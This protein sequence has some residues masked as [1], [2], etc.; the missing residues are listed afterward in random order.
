M[1]K[2]Y[3]LALLAAI[4]SLSN[5]RP[6]KEKRQLTK[7][8]I[9]I[10]L[11]NSYV[12]HLFDLQDHQQKDSL[13]FYLQNE[14]PTLRYLSALSF[15]SFKEKTAVDKLLPLLQADPS[16]EVRTAAAYA[17][18][19]IGE[20]RAEDGLLQAF[21]R[22]DTAFNRHLNATILEAIGKCG[23][24]KSLKA[25]ATVGTYVPSDTIL[26]EGQCRGIY[27]FALRDL[28]TSEG[29]AKMVNYA[30][31]AL[32]PASVRLLAASYLQRAKKIQPD[33]T[34]AVTLSKTLNT[35]SDP[36]LRMAVAIGLGKAKTEAALNALLRQ[37]ETDR[38]YRVQCNAIRGLGNFEYS[39]VA[40]KIYLFLKN[41]NPHV[42][43]TAAQF[44]LNNGKPTD[45]PDYWKWAKDDSITATPSLL[46]YGAALKHLSSGYTGSKDA[47]NSEL[48]KRFAQTT[49][50]YERV[51]IIRAMT[52]YPWNY[53]NIK[54]LTLNS[55]LPLLR[56][57]GIDALVEICKLP[58]FNSYFGDGRRRVREDMLGF[59][60]EALANG[61]VALVAGAAQALREPNPDFKIMVGEEKSFL[62]DALIKLKLPKE[63]ETYNELQKTIDYFN[64][65][66]DSSPKQPDFTHPIDWKIVSLVTEKTRAVIQTKYGNISLVFF[67]KIAPGS[68]ANFIQLSNS[69]FF[70]GK[71]FHRVVS[72]FVVQGGCPRGDGFGALDYAIRSEFNPSVRYE[73]EG[74]V[75]M[76]SSGNH[77]EGTQ[78]F[79]TNA[80]A[81]HLD[82][83]YT[84]FAKVVEGMDAVQKIQ[85]GDIIEKITVVY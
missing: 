68:V 44:F 39:K 78:W 77:T 2:I 10:D 8:G 38:D 26:L 48:S 71:T 76:A 32:M 46:L 80:P 22:Q 12:Q 40:P 20:A 21:Q 14:N 47:I 60:K 64:G 70:N 54:A 7:T 31:D 37:L 81:P 52:Q 61:D 28:T 11:S 58:N 45:A 53:R 15:A 75:G 55:D 3:F 67:P 79:I 69:G 25:L 57:A 4:A 35:E 73:T 36:S 72:N 16:L 56:T 62:N 74:M 63:I 49:N 30:S 85:V 66:T 24:E 19:Q 43:N 18:G 29:T 23:S 17:L 42:A 65:K 27:R 9:N 6:P 83:G 51:F 13:F 1:K 34:M 50:N 59:F 84:I 5:C 82:G 33:S 41:K